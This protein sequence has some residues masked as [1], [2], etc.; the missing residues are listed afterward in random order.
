MSIRIN[1]G[2]TENPELNTNDVHYSVNA[3]NEHKC[4]NLYEIAST[5]TLLLSRNLDT[6]K[7]MNVTHIWL[8]TTNRAEDS[9]YDNMWIGSSKLL[10]KLLLDRTAG[11]LVNFILV[12][13]LIIT[14]LFKMISI[15]FVPLSFYFTVSS[16]EEPSFDWVK[17]VTV[18]SDLQVEFHLQDCQTNIPRL[19]VSGWT[20]SSPEQTVDRYVSTSNIVVVNQTF[21]AS[22]SLFGSFS[23]KF[24]DQNGVS[25]VAQG[26]I[27]YAI[28]LYKYV[29]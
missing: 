7:D 25:R 6:N 29:L 8:R 13:E 21:L 27:Y 3:E 15:I 18:T 12:Q 19:E 4:L 2:N 5:S 23:L 24:T 20:K 14:F 1:Y 28:I 11:K 22:G 16:S 10:G 17:K 26:N 9:F